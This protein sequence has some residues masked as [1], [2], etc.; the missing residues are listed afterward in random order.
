MT[1]QTI[2]KAD[3]TI[4]VSTKE[5]VLKNV[6]SYMSVF[7]ESC[8]KHEDL[9]YLAHLNQPNLARDLD[10]VRQLMGIETIDFYG[11]VHGSTVGITY[12]GMFPDRV[13][14]FIIDG[15]Y[16]IIV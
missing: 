11:W 12:A 13:G 5:A 15:M 4:D 1:A 16:H 7:G 8:A 6:R 9:E 3:F 10:L 14:R 2:G